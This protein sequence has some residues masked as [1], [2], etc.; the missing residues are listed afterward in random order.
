MPGPDCGL[1]MPMSPVV[2]RWSPAEDIVDGSCVR[3]QP[4]M[5]DVRETKALHMMTR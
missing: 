4:A 2:V 5:E 1:L 3:C